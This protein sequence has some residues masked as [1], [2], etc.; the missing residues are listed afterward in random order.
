MVITVS[1]LLLPASLSVS[2]FPFPYSLSSDS[3]KRK[4]IGSV[5][6]ADLPCLASSWMAGLR[7]LL[8]QAPSLL[9]LSLVI[10]AEESGIKHGPGPSKKNL[11]MGIF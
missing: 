3:C 11:S 1:L 7:L 9:A 6:L 2:Y 5:M 10:M 4:L 8:G